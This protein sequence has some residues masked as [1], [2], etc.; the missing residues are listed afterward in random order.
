M[1]RIYA[2]NYVRLGDAIT[3]VRHIFEEPDLSAEKKYAVETVLVE[4]AKICNELDMQVSSKLLGVR[5]VDVPGS[6]FPK[7]RREMELIIDVVMSELESKLLLYIP[8]HRVK[9]YDI[10]L[11]TKIIDSFPSAANEIGIAGRAI[12]AELFTASVFHSM[13]A[14]EIGLHIL[15]NELDV[16][17]P[18]DPKLADWHVLLDQTEAKIKDMK[19]LPKSTKKDD[20]LQFYSESASQFRYFKDGWRIRVSHSRATYME[21]QAIKVLD[22]VINFFETLS[23]RLK[24]PVP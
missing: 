17:L 12:V 15:A 24:E 23:L 10:I 9:Y 6:G 1:L 16:A 21:S 11:Q 14:A 22:H 20:D 13:R 7:S 8:S 18:F 4:L 5:I 19:N 2:E 3:R